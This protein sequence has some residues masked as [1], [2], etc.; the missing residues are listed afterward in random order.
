MSITISPEHGFMTPTTERAAG[1]PQSAQAGCL[2]EQFTG[3]VPSR[4][5]RTMAEILKERLAE[6]DR[7]SPAP[8]FIP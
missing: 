2:Q 8:V 3:T 7:V 1:K 6:A 4:S 5:E